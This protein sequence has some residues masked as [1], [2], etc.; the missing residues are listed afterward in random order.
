MVI[1]LDGVMGLN[2]LV[3][4]LLLLG[5]N[6][7]AGY[8]AGTG[9]AA[10]AAAMGGGYAGACL[11]PGF[12]FLANNLWRLVCLGLMSMAAF[13]MSRSA[14]NR[15]ILFILL[16]MALGGLVLSLDVRNLP[17]LVA[18]AGLL[19][20]ICRMGFR[21]APMGRRLLP[22]IIRHQGRTAEFLALQ[23][24]GNT[25]HDPLTG[26]RVLVADLS[27]AQQLLDLPLDALRDPVQALEKMPGLRLIP[28]HTVGG[29]GFL[30]GARCDQVCIDGICTG[31]LVAFTG[32]TF[33]S[34]EYQGLT[35]G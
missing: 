20:A 28:C 19:A 9:R 2:F 12:S 6:R 7:L 14:L 25:L 15:G 32:E 24:T 16:S 11:L 30:L 23:D 26:E 29:N 22:V 8:P 5:V 1:Y 10:A 34:G 13:G 33:P 4:W 31:G 27:I 21:G 17:G 35:G 18:C 3:D